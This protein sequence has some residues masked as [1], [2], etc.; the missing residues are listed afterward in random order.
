MIRLLGLEGLFEGMTYCDYA[1][2]ELVCKPKAESYSRAIRDAEVEEGE[3]CWFVDD[4]VANCRGA[5]ETGWGKVVWKLE[6]EEDGE[7]WDGERVWELE[8]LRGLF[9]DVFKD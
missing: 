1:E 9:K 4:S 8:E 6:G 7:G 2:E 3:R 5:R